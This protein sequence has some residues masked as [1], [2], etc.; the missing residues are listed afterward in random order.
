VAFGGA[1]PLHAADVARELAI[2]RVLV[3]RVPGHFSAVGMLHA[4][5][6]RDHAQTF[7]QPLRP[8]VLVQA[9]RV[10]RE[11]EARGRGALAGS[12][13]PFLEILVQRAADMRYVGQEHTVTVP[14][15]L[16]LDTP[17]AADVLKRAFD[18]AH[19]RQYGHAAREEPVELVTLRSAVVGVVAKPA[20]P[21]IARG[22]A[23]PADAARRATRAVVFAGAARRPTS[24]W[25]RDALAAGNVIEGPAVVEESASTTLVPPGARLAVDEAGNL[26]LEV[27]G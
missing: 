25:R 10:H 15:P 5:L 8:E 3:P 14:V 24:V 1:G 17:S 18:E 6:R 26:V 11:L 19:E 22:A 21:A 9:E 4:D 23:T 12:E 16:D 7:L 2:R 20:P 13:T 27:E